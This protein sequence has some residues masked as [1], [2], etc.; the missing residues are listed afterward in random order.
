MLQLPELP[1]HEPAA[2]FA[3]LLAAALLAPQLAERLRVP[4]LVGL[5]LVGALVGPPGLGLLERDGAV[6]MLGGAGLLYLMFLAGLELDLDELA[7]HRRDSLL[8]GAATFA[9]PM[10]LGIPLMGALGFELLPSILLASCWASHTLLTYPVFRR[11]GTATNRAVATSVGATILTDTA[12]LLVLA[13]VARAVGGA[14]DGWFWLSVTGALGVVLVACLV[15]LPRLGRWV[16]AT[17]GQDRNARVTFTLLA[18]F[19]AAAVAELVGLEGI[20]GAFLAGLALNRLVPSDSLL[21]ARVEVIGSTVLVPLFLLSV[22]MLVDPVLLL[23]PRTL[24]LAVS[25]TAVAMGAKWLAAELTGRHLGYDADERTAM[26]ALSNAQAAATLAAVFVGVEVGLLEV[27]VVNAVIGVVLVTCLAASWAAARSA[28]R[29]PAAS[30]SRALGQVVVVPVANPASAGPLTALAAALARHDGGLVVP[31]TV[32]PDTAAESA[33]SEARLVSEAA[34]GVALAAGVEA[35]AVTR[36]DTDAVAGIL[37]AVPEHDGTLL[38]LGWAGPDAGGVT[39]ADAVVRRARCATVLARLLDGASATWPRVVVAVEEDDLAPRGLSGLRL[40]VTLGS[41]LARDTGARLV[42]L[43][44][45]DDDGLRSLLASTSGR[46]PQVVVDERR[47]VEAL[48]D[49]LEPGDLLVVPS[50]P[51]DRVLHG[52]VARLARTLP[53]VDLL[54]A[55]DHVTARR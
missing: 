15:V 2:A 8:F 29:L 12:A 38:L 22:G 44:H 9:V 37:R 54:V 41:G 23:Q 49:L 47:R 27:Y 43:S 3:V 53:D 6:A 11:H 21:M 18:A 34:E 30:R 52:P 50:A 28:P 16:F 31:V 5:I 7:E 48:I 4:G 10:G 42:V 19:A 13:V 14:L 39:V 55:V 32:V 35:R 20:I 33:L 36:V 17:I 1:L 40:A 46:D 45:R 26:F 25:F 51:D 24:A